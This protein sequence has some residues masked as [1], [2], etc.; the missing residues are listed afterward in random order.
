[1]KKKFIVSVIALSMIL[2]CG[3]VK[4]SLDVQN[5]D[6]QAN[7]TS[8]V[9]NVSFDVT[10][11]NLSNKEQPKLNDGVYRN[12]SLGTMFPS[13]TILNLNATFLR[14]NIENPTKTIIYL[15]GEL[16]KTIEFSNEDEEIKLD[17]SGNYWIV[18]MNDENNY[19]DI[20]DKDNNTALYYC[21]N[22]PYNKNEVFAALLN[23]TKI[24]INARY[25]EKQNTLLME[26]AANGNKMIT[27]MLIARGADDSLVN[28]DNKTALIL[29]KEKLALFDTSSVDVQNSAEFQNY[30]FI[31]DKFLSDKNTVAECRSGINEDCKKYYKPVDVIKTDK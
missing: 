5:L 12:Y 17:E 27:M 22:A 24:D 26:A 13:S 21:A 18:V 8:A 30:K 11:T 6:N 23:N 29:A 16:Y 25:G 3:C 20:T 2:F 15:N 28:A 10:K 7:N 14:D 31:A 4:N 1:M 19:V 9:Q